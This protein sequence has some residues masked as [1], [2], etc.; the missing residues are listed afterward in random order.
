MRSWQAVGQQKFL[1][2]DDVVHWEVCG[3]ISAR[4]LTTIFE[5]GVH[6][7]NARGYALFCINIS[8]DWS[9]PL[10]AR[11]A[12]AQFHRTHTAVGATAIVGISANKALF[13]DLVLRGI[14]KVSGHR[15][16]TRF[17]GAMQEAAVWLDDARVQLHERLRTQKQ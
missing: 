16:N 14:A 3:N 7:Q 15:P 9:F 13:I 6:I 1:V 5:E 10:E 8:G 17:F 11:R 2:E 4:E 12:L